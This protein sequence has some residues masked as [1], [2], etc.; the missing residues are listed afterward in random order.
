MPANV[1][2]DLPLAR[3]VDQN[4]PVRLLDDDAIGVKLEFHGAILQLMTEAPVKVE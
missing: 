4:W 1:P 2:G 3:F